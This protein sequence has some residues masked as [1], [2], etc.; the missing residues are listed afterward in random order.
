MYAAERLVVRQPDDVDALV[1]FLADLL[2]AAYLLLVARVDEAEGE[3]VEP[4]WKLI[5]TTTSGVT[6]GL[7]CLRMGLRR[8]P[9][10]SGSNW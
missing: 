7:G 1:D 5:D 10:R 8:S 2:I 3:L 9:R 4:F 6:D